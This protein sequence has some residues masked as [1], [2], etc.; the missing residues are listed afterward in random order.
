MPRYGFDIKKNR[1]MK[2]KR[3]SREGA[4]SLEPQKAHLTVDFVVVMK[5][6]GRAFLH[7]GSMF[8][9]VVSDWRQ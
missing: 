6:G 8:A 2:E 5:N 7:L 4:Y 3:H 1:L 9:T